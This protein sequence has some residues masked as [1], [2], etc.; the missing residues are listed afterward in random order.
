GEPVHAEAATDEVIPLSQDEDPLLR[1]TASYTL[2]LLE[3][4][5]SRARLT[6]LLSDSD[7]GVR[8]NSAVALVRH[9][10]RAG[11]AVLLDAVTSGS[12][13]APAATTDDL[14]RFLA[15]KNALVAIGELTPL[16]TEEER[17]ELQGVIQPLSDTHAE[18]AI[19]VAAQTTLQ[20]LASPS[21]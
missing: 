4:P 7:P 1:V 16:L 13:S 11:L 20:N 8:L 15:V 14:A 9:N 10:D 12:Q 6:T 3:T 18:P 5:E 19:R 17:K 21:P 2:G